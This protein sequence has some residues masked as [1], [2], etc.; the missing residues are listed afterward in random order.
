MLQ[1]RCNNNGGVKMRTVLRKVGEFTRGFDPCRFL[2]E[3]GVGTEI[4]MRQEGRGLVIE[5]VKTVRLRCFDGYQAENETDAWEEEMTL[6][7]VELV[8]AFVRY[9]AMRYDK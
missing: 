7:P 1:Y 8:K 3:C 4:E 6:T 2:A 5:P 9:D